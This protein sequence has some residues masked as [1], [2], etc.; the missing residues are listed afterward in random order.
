MEKANVAGGDLRLRCLANS[1][2]ILT[3]ADRLDVLRN[4]DSMSFSYCVGPII[5]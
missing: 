5:Q 1:S 2:E 3:F 4:V